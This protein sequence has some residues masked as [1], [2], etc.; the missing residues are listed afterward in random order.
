MTRL[1]HNGV[2]GYALHTTSN[3]TRAGGKINCDLTEAGTDM[4]AV[5]HSPS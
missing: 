1:H 4:T 5:N 3:S 2:G